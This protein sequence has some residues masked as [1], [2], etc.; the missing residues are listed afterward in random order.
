MKLLLA[1]FALI[2]QIVSAQQPM[3]IF[4]FSE[5]SDISQW[6]IV[7]DV[8]M[9]GRSNGHFKM[10]DDGHGAFYGNISLDNNGGFSSLRY[11]FNTIDASNYGMFSI[12]V[13]GDGKTYQFR[14]RDKANHR[15]SYIF[16]FETSGDWQTITIPFNKM[17]PS[18]RGYKLDA[19]NYSGQQVE[20]IGF[21]I[22]NKKAE[23]FRLIIE[24]ISLK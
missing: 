14:V 3:T 18:F 21:L 4:K 24:N 2:I 7:D 6:R 11:S 22:G 20:D 10:N 15:Y 16:Y 13:K 12:K 8:V 17:Y 9:G 23:K 1:V 19:P 5:N